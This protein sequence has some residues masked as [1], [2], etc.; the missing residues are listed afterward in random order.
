MRGQESIRTAESI[1]QPLNLTAA[2]SGLGRP[3]YRRVYERALFPFSRRALELSRTWNLRIWF[4]RSRPRR[5][6]SL[7]DG[8]ADRCAALAGGSCRGWWRD[9]A[10]ERPGAGPDGSVR[11]TRSRASSRSRPKRAESRAARG[12]AEW[13]PRPRGLGAAASGRAA[14]C[15]R[16]RRLHGTSHPALALTTALDMRPLSAHCY[17][18]LGRALRTAND[19]QAAERHLATAVDLFRNGHGLLAR[20]GFHGE[21]QANLS[22]SRA[23]SVPL[24]RGLA[25]LPAVSAHDLLHRSP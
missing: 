25:H 9:A 8:T 21:G 13:P 2:T 20:P 23:L 3:Y 24:L 7:R 10:V 19:H 17:F 6:E 5:S 1:E 22:A 14:L 11:R 18:G 4:R 12:A 16:T 15:G